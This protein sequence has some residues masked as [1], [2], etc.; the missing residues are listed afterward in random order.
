VAAYDAAGAIDRAVEER[1]EANVMFAS[2]VSQVAFL[3]ALM[4]RPDVDWTRV[5]GFHMDEYLGMGPGHPA[6]F[7][8]YM[9]DHVVARVH[10]AEFHELAGD[11]GEPDREI[12]R[13]T[14][15]LRDHPLD[16][17]CLGI[18]ENGHLAF[19]DPANADFDDAVDVKVAELD[20]RCRAQQVGEGHF[21]TIGDVPPRA[22]TV[23][24]PALLRARTLVVVVP[25]TRK[26]KPVHDA[27]RGPV[28]P[29]CPASVL[30]SHPDASLYLDAESSSLLGS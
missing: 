7:R 15:L 24:I 20:D 12:E 16:L 5:A 11:T 3:D 19:N 21:A 6:S 22:L 27:V 18:G 9:R 28:S 4:H 17:C 29:E 14:A 25:E 8:R 2:G 30:R 13:Y 23:T 26:A 10:P 1:G